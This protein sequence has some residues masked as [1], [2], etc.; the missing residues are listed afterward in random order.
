[1]SGKKIDDK[2]KQ[3]VIKAYEKGISKKKIAKKFGISPSSV[4]RIV[5][6]KVTKYSPEKKA[7]TDAKIELQ[8]RI[9][10]VERKLLELE[11]KIIEY[12]S[13]KK[14]SKTCYNR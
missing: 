12:E 5:R 13:K 7:K 14:A 4:D 2:T 1:M 6:K 11:K 8:K 9:E 10:D 3:N